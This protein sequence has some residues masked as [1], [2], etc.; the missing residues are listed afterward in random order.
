MDSDHPMRVQG[1]ILVVDDDLSTRQT[2]AALMERE[3]HEVRCAPSGQTA[4]MFA[5]EDPPDLILL[6]IRLLDVDGLQVCRHL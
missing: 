5:Q 6:D 3:G 2:L 1:N 4:R